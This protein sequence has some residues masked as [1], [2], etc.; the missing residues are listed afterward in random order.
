ML[1]ALPLLLAA[2]APQEPE[3]LGLMEALAAGDT[4]RVDGILFLMNDEVITESMVAAD[5]ER[6]IRLNPDAPRNEVFSQSLSERLFDLIAREG[7]NRF[8]LDRA[9]LDEQVAARIQEM[10][11]DAGSRARFEQGIRASGYDMTS[12]RQALEADLIRLTWRSIV[13]GDQPSPLEGKRNSITITPAEVKE[14]Y[15][16]EPERWKQEK[17]LVWT[18]LQ[19][20]DD[21][22]GSGL[23][24]ARTMAAQLKAKTA[25]LE[26]ASAAANSSLQDQ[27]DPGL[28]NLRPDL[29]EFLSGAVEGSVSEIDPIPGLGAQ[30]V[31]LAQVLP[32]RDIGFEEAQVPITM[33]IRRDRYNLIVNEAI[34]ELN[35]T[36]YVW[37][38]DE[39]ETFMS[40][41]PGLSRKAVEET[42][43]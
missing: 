42:E 29:Q 39:L 14:A 20:F 38:P 25:T 8:G 31:Y 15:A 3:Q 22:R 30:F 27:G 16:K 13:T 2:L 32:A 33:A 28:K 12:F 17:S 1:A 40:S 11:Q 21:D 6:V 18:T 37:F 41:V 10:I 26:Q 24:R 19:F 43:F 4:V 23:E 7:F 9:L 36:S 35:R 34:S 5:A